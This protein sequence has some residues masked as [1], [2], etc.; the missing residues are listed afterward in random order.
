MKFNGE[1]WR[2]IPVKKQDENEPD[3]FV[4]VKKPKNVGGLIPYARYGEDWS[5]TVPNRILI[6]ELLLVFDRTEKDLLDLINQI[7]GEKNDVNS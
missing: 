4:V 7:E 2:R 1:I 3:E 6:R 5:T